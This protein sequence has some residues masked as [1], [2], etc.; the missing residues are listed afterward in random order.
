MFE[1]SKLLGALLMPLSALGLLALLATLLLFTRHWRS[2]RGVLVVVLL[3]FG[4]VSWEPTASRLLLPLEQR[5]PA[6]LDATAVPVER[7]EAVIV[8][9]H[10]HRLDPQ[11]PITAQLNLMATARLLEG[12]RIQQAWPQSALLLTGG[13]VYSAKP[14]SQL[15]QQLLETLGLAPVQVVAFDTPRN[16]REEAVR[17]AAWVEA[18]G[19]DPAALVLVTEASH[20]PRAM[21]L[22]RGVGLDPLP[23]PTAHRVRAREPEAG[24]PA[25]FRPSAHALRM[26]ERAVHEYAGLLWARLRGWTTPGAAALQSE[27]AGDGDAA[28]EAAGDRMEMQGESEEEGVA[29]SSVARQH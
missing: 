14:N 21:A 28:S 27:S 5:Y 22:F 25:Q 8:L 18:A 7:V 24:S 2:G 15:M 20:M 11:L 1:L 6:L 17:V 19:V 10:G 12:V 29:A 9:G 26:S 3:L 16:T 4:V 13:A 23:A